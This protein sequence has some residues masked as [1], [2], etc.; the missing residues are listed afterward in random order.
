MAKVKKCMPI[1]IV[2]FVAAGVC[3]AE[4]NSTAKYLINTPVSILD[5]GMYKL[6]Q[7]IDTH[8][9]NLVIDKNL[10]QPD[11][12]LVYYDP[13]TNNIKI[14]ISYSVTDSQFKNISKKE[15]QNKMT[16]LIGRYKSSLK[17]DPNTGRPFKDHS[18]IW[19]HFSHAGDPRKDEPITIK[20]D[21]DQMTEIIIAVVSGTDKIKSKSPLAGNNIYWEE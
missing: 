11:A 8:R 5:F 1:L 19:I 6:G 17:I 12:A 20:N 18:N 16:G 7:Y 15:L 3:N 9:R 14:E 21:L 2:A 10:I 4:S 13:G